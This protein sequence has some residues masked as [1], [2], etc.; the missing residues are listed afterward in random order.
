VTPAELREA[1]KA[2]GLIPTEELVRALKARGY[3]ACPSPAKPVAQR[4]FGRTDRSGSCWLWMGSK[5]RKGYG[6]I[7]NGG[8]TRQAH[9]LAWELTNGGIPSGM[10]VMHKCDNPS[11]INPAHLS[12]GT[13]AD[14]NL[15]KIAKGRHPTGAD[16]VTT[17]KLTPDDVRA[18]RASRGTSRRIAR[19]YGVSEANIRLIRSRQSWR[20]VA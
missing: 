6:L 10:V 1:R 20:H 2:L 9:R 11:C 12:V 14:N 19:E 7:K 13:I 16:A 17:A 8:K 15:D 4:L 18:I 3:R 5:T